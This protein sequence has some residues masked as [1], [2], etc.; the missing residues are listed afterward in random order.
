MN[1][2]KKKQQFY[3]NKT[4]KDGHIKWSLRFVVL[5]NLDDKYFRF[6]NIFSVP[7][8]NPAQSTF[9]FPSSPPNEYTIFAEYL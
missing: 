2:K 4:V 7:F 6:Y 9:P 5:K 8:I 3:W 1:G